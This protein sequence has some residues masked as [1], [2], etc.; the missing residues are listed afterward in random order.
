M[1]SLRNENMNDSFG[2]ASLDAS[3]KVWDN[4]I[5]RG[6]EMKG[7]AATQHVEI[8]MVNKTENSL[9]QLNTYAATMSNIMNEHKKKE[10]AFR[11]NA[12]TTVVVAPA[13]VIK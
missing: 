7:S 10:E 12:D 3:M 11:K 2:L 9:K 1:G 8:N 13:P 5:V 6:G 4:L